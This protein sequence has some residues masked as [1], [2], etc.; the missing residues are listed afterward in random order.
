[1][2]YQLA[3]E[4]FV[5]GII[6]SFACGLGVL[7]LLWPNLKIEKHVGMAYALTAGMMVAAS[8]YNLL[9]P[10]LA[11]GSDQAT[12]FWPVLLVV[13][14]LYA[15]ALA[16]RA[17]HEWLTPER[18]EQ[19]ILKNSGGRTAALVF[20]AMTAHS[21]PEGVAVGVGYGAEA[22]G[23][24]F[25]GLGT[26][27]AIAIAIHNIPEGLAVALP[28]RV[29]GASMNTCFWAAFLSSLP[30]PLA[31][32]PACLAV[33]QVEP[34]MLP[35]LGSAAGAMLYLVMVELI[36]DALETRTAP[37]TAWMFMI[38]FGL[39]LLTQAAL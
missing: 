10:A 34:L 11:E 30:Q 19:G 12:R 18:L 21:I 13:G 37:Q 23:P 4:S 25:D 1:M 31:A 16:M 22:A 3:L 27:V 29:G 28:L 7:P 39:M 6:A 20:A 2:N 35:M 9:M 32:V 17:V 38:G 15:G 36:P 26:L 24:Q 5:A 14:G 8:V 33:E